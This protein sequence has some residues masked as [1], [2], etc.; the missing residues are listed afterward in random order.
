[1]T[2]TAGNHITR[3]AAAKLLKVSPRQVTT[4]IQQGRLDGAY[5][6]GS[7]WAIPRE[8]VEELAKARKGGFKKGRKRSG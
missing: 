6:L 2:M 7:I 3:A 4:Y 5:K 1:M 8:A